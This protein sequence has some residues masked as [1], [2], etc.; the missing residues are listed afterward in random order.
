[1]IK[2]GSR[3][4][5]Y[6]GYHPKRFVEGKGTVIAVDYGPAEHT[7]EVSRVS[8]TIRWDNG[9]LEIRKEDDETIKTSL[10]DVTPKLFVNVYL[11]DQAWGGSE[12]GGWNYDTYEP[13][14]DMSVQAE[15]LEAARE[16][17][18]E[19]LEWCRE[20]NKGRRPIGGITGEAHYEVKLEAWPGEHLPA[21]RPVYS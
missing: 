7:G 15:S 21:N 5:D 14:E 10:A 1:M 20:Q 16:R 11:H 8:T 19:M 13:I 4:Q 3:V 6:A 2:V 9:R 18:K 12:E 17:H